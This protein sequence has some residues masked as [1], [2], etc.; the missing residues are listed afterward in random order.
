MQPPS[1]SALG[2][3]VTRVR[4]FNLGSALQRALLR[5]CNSNQSTLARLVG[6]SNYLAIVTVALGE[7]AAGRLLVKKN[8]ADKLVKTVRSMGVSCHRA[9]FHCIEKADAVDGTHHRGSF[10][11]DEPK[12]A[13]AVVYFGMNAYFA[14][15][16]EWAEYTG[17]HHVAGNLFG[18]PDCCVAHFEQSNEDEAD[19]LPSTIKH[20]GPYPREMNPLTFYVYGVPNLLFHFA[21]SPECQRS[22][23]LAETRRVF[24]GSLTRKPR[25]MK[26]LGAG[27]AIY[28]PEL[29]IGLITR[30]QQVDASEYEI[31][32]VTTRQAITRML[33]A[34]REWQRIRMYGAHR[35]RIGKKIYSGNLT[36]A[37]QF[38]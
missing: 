27:I 12:G 28:G 23:A 36:F 37:A 32:E 1:V 25:Q 10:V 18:Y 24:I 15:G 7:R 2:R 9:K 4:S 13:L 34:G 19:K 8:I 3:E 35:F 16:A 5:D 20:T 14:K 17:N 30:Y 31:Q 11:N 26:A 21:C 38:Q 6:L 29:G 33:F 22:A